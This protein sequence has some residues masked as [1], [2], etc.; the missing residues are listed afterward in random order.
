MTNEL[1]HFCVL[2]DNRAK[3]TNGSVL[4]SFVIGLELEHGLQYPQKQINTG[5]FGQLTPSS[6][7]NDVRTLLVIKFIPCNAILDSLTARKKSPT[8]GHK[9]HEHA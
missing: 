1:F 3:I 8:S 4:P 5:G 7:S 2:I 9:G 6:N